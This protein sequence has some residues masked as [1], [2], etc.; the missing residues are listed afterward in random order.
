MLVSLP[1]SKHTHTHTHPRTHIRK[2]SHTHGHTH[3]HTYANAAIHIGRERPTSTAK[4]RIGGSK[5]GFRPIHCSFLSVEQASQARRREGGVVPPLLVQPHPAGGDPGGAVPPG[6]YQVCIAHQFPS[7]SF[8][9]TS[10]NSRSASIV[11][12]LPPQL[13]A[14]HFFIKCNVQS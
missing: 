1:T 13:V 7:C 4:A 14:Q 3:T 2:C 12:V 11:N 9:T 8:F 6:V 5:R 10:A